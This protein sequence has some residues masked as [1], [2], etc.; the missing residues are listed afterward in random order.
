MH[1]IALSEMLHSCCCAVAADAAWQL[2]LY[3]LLLLLLVPP[4]LDICLCQLHLGHAG[5]QLAVLLHHR[6]VNLMHTMPQNSTSEDSDAVL[7]W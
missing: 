6:R 5:A 7:Q 3:V 4:A 2:D 1:L